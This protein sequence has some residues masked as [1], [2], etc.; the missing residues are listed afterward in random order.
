[1]RNDF[2]EPHWCVACLEQCLTNGVAL[3]R[4]V[5]FLPTHLFVRDQVRVHAATHDQRFDF[6]FHHHLKKKNEMTGG[7]KTTGGSSPSRTDTCAPALYTL[8]PAGNRIRQRF[9]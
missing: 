9:N 4:L 7:K 5:R 2:S 3:I 6:G 1:M 8:P